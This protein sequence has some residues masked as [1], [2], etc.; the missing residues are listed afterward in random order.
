MRRWELY[1]EASVGSTARN[2]KDATSGKQLREDGDQRLSRGTYPHVHCM[3]PG[4]RSRELQQRVRLTPLGRSLGPHSLRP[5]N[6][7]RQM[8]S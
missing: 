4:L 3:G 2:G 5:R 8:R 1:D 7:L 6:R